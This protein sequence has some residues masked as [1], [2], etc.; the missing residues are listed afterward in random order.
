MPR[1][2]PTNLMCL[3]CFSLFPSGTTTIHRPHGGGT[4]VIRPSH[5]KRPGGQ[6]HTTYFTHRPAAT[7]IVTTTVKLPSLS[8]NTVPDLDTA[9]SIS[10]GVWEHQNL[11]FFPFLQLEIV[12]FLLMFSPI[13]FIAFARRINNRI[14]ESE[15]TY[16]TMACHNTTKF[17]N[18]TT[19][20]TMG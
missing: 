13:F 1:E 12:F 2:I 4:L 18:K 20:N 10:T 7:D 9:S 19:S 11:Y 3:H 15:H 14:M 8:E 5:T 16:D 17:Y 6:Q